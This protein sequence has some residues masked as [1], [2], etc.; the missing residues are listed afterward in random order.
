VLINQASYLTRAP[1]FVA[2]TPVPAPKNAHLFMDYL[3]LR[4]ILP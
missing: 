2:V 4:Y 3:S 1:W